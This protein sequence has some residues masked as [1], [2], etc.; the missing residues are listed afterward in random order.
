MADLGLEEVQG[1]VAD[2]ARVW[3]PET[4]VST[5]GEDP[6][7]LQSLASGD[8]VSLGVIIGAAVG[9]TV[10]L[11][12]LAVMLYVC[13]VTLRRRSQE[14]AASKK[15][16]DPFPGD[17]GSTIGSSMI[18]PGSVAHPSLNTAGSMGSTFSGRASQ[19][20]LAP[21]RHAKAHHMHTPSGG[22]NGGGLPAHGGMGSDGDWMGQQQGPGGMAGGYAPPPQIPEE[23]FG[24]QQGGRYHQMPLQGG[25]AGHEG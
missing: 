19:V 6:V 18:P 12:V 10:V 16:A 22:P 3:G 7:L 21:N 25:Y 11:I 2:V 17:L 8:S 15:A 20:P 24:Q 1:A 23:P 5:P 13:C 4:V 14:E 9:G